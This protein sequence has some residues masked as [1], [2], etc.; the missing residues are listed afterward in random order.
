MKY[1][2][3]FALK[4]KQEESG[5][6]YESDGF[7]D[8]PVPI[9]VPEITTIIKNFVYDFEQVAMVE[10][11]LVKK[12]TSKKASNSNDTNS[13]T[14]NK[15]EDSKDRLE[16]NA[17]PLRGVAGKAYICQLKK[18]NKSSLDRLCLEIAS[19]LKK[20]I[21]EISPHEILSS[22]LA[23]D[24]AGIREIVELRNYLSS[25]V[26]EKSDTYQNGYIYIIPMN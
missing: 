23:A 7:I 5:V 26:E 11:K 25:F 22:E 4:L 15:N 9:S 18:L 1:H 12:H 19:Y 21:S 2:L 8:R 10:P 3:L 13:K 16:Q 20:C 14:A 24:F 6:I 17:S